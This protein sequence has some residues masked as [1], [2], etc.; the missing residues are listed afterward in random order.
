M[1]FGG[2]CEDG[3]G[4]EEVDKVLDGGSSEVG[5]AG[6]LVCVSGLLSGRL[7]LGGE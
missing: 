1:D 2:L 6:G 7:V 3:G 4:G 5:V